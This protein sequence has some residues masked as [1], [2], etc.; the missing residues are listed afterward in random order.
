[1]NTNGFTHPISPS[2]SLGNRI[3]FPK[4][5]LFY[6]VQIRQAIRLLLLPQEW[7]CDLDMANT[8]QSKHRDWFRDELIRVLPEDGGDNSHSS[9]G[10]LNGHEKILCQRWREEM[11]L[12]LST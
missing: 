2:L 10:L 8:H 5:N 6:T 1:M 11:G 4:D 7:T 12:C 9:L 3:F